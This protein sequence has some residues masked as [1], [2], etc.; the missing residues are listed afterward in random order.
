MSARPSRVQRQID[1]V[2]LMCSAIAGCRLAAITILDHPKRID[3]TPPGLIPAESSILATLAWLAVHLRLPFR[4]VAAALAV[5]SLVFNTLHS[6]RRS[7]PRC[8]T[9]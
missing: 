1:A 4:I 2:A 9:H 7:A 6:L 5:G 8:E 3:A